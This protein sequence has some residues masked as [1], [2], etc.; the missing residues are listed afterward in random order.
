M[1]VLGWEKAKHGLEAWSAHLP[2][3]KLFTVHCLALS[4][5]VG[6]KMSQKN[7]V[8]ILSLPACADSYLCVLGD[9][10]PEPPL[11]PPEVRSLN[12]AHFQV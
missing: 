7:P 4:A 11:L 9:K 6:V 2:P 8:R 5:Q 10:Q 3:R 1:S 12:V